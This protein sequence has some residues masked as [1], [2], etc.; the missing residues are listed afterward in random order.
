M[1]GRNKIQSIISFREPRC[2]TEVRSF[3]RLANYMNKFVPMLATLDEPLRRL[4]HKD[5]RF[6]WTEE[7]AKAF[8]AMKKAM[9]NIAILGFYK[10]EDRTALMTDA[11]PHGLGAILI[12]FDNSDNNSVISFASKAL[13]DTEHLPAN[14]ARVGEVHWWT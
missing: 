3:L 7:H 2:E 1:P 4:L 11:S 13:T 12:Q 14:N 5:T 6:G 9:G 8:N 10:V